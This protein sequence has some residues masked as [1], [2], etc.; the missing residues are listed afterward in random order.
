MKL[1]DLAGSM[2][3]RAR[4]MLGINR[5][6]AISREYPRARFCSGSSRWSEFSIRAICAAR[7][8]EFMLS[9][10]ETCTGVRAVTMAIQGT[11]DAA[12]GTESNAIRQRHTV[13]RRTFSGLL[14]LIYPCVQRF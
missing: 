12:P 5:L 7:H 1:A 3:V 11:T 13:K 8:S 9:A 6:Q 10:V 4:L 14:R 2:K